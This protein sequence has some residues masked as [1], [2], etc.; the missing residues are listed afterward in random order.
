MTIGS[1]LLFAAL[2]F[3]C[4]LPSFSFAAEQK[5]WR[6][7]EVFAERKVPTLVGLA[8]LALAVGKVIAATVFGHSS[9][10]LLLWAALAYMVGGPLVLGMLGRLSGVASLILAPVLSVLS[11]FFAI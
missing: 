7:G 6:Q 5:G 9:F 8:C 3:A 4:A 10:W 2:A 11:L 1:G